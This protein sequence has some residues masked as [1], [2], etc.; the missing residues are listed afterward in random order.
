VTRGTI[1]R[2]WALGA[3]SV[4]LSL[5]GSARGD[6]RDAVVKIYTVS[7]GPDYYN[8]W[9]DHAVGLESGSGAIISGNRILTNAHVVSDQRLIEAR[10]NGDPQ[11]H[12]ARLLS[13]SHESDLALLAV[14]DASFFTGTTALELGALPELQEEVVVYGFPWGGDVLSITKGVV[15]RIE[16]QTYVHSSRV[17]L[18]GQIDAAINPGNSGGPVVVNGRLV[19]VAMQSI[20]GAQ[21]LG[22]MVPVTMVAHFLKDMEDGRLDGHAR[23]GIRNEGMENPDLR[24]KYRVPPDKTGILVLSTVPGTPADGTL[25]RGDVMLSIDR[26]PVA[27]DGT[28][29]FRPR[30]R[31]RWMYFLDL[32][33]V[34][35]A[36]ELEILR[37]GIPK[38]LTL[39]L[40]ASKRPYELVP[41]TQYDRPA[42]YYIYGGLV[43]CPLTANYLEAWGP[44]WRYHAPANLLAFLSEDPTAD[45][46]Q[47]VLLVKVLASPV[48]EGY[49]ELGS[50]VI[51]EVD[52]EKVKNLREFIRLVEAPRK[53]SPYVTITYGEGDLLVLDRER[54]RAARDQI[55]KTYHIGADRSADLQGP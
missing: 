26:H 32:K 46:D 35:E 45:R 49:H 38:T 11:R 4:V 31:T 20:P 41:P 29:E 40:P 47:V 25:R 10:R 37:D 50:T 55:L 44:E 9:S 15:S 1:R 13:I 54:V 27:N 34:G 39:A 53:P 18:A 14:D 12:V 24:K 52:G 28:V 51:R 16:H 5:A 7:Q 2:A 8:P 17:F 33:Q 36:V 43:V 42:T 48:N 21:S 23:L 19:G 30:E 6:V 22:Y 3:A